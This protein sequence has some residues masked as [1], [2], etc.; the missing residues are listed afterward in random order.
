MNLLY[1]IRL[2]AGEGHHPSPRQ[3]D[4]NVNVEAEGK[5]PFQLFKNL[6]VMATSSPSLS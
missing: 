3:L 2:R 4:R 6:R 5:A 1:I